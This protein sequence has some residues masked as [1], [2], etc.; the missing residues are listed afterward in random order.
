MTSEKTIGPYFFE[1]EN[2]NAVTVTGDRYR[3]K[4][5]KFRGRCPTGPFWMR[6]IF[7]I[8]Y[9]NPAYWLRDKRPGA[10]CSMHPLFFPVTAQRAEPVETFAENCERERI[11]A[12]SALEF[13]VPSFPE[14]LIKISGGYAGSTYTPPPTPP[15]MSRSRAAGLHFFLKYISNQ[16]FHPFCDESGVNRVRNSPCEWQTDIRF[17]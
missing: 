17:T 6:L 12:P 11:M 1:D 13:R 4:L 5:E 9:S 15:R 14:S 3:E 10:V 16:Y 2:A 8:F 7:R